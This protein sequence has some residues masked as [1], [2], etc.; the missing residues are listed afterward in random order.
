MKNTH[1]TITDVAREAGVSKSTVSK[2]LNHWP[3]ISAETTDR[4]NDVIARLGYIPNQRAVNFARGMSHS[5]VYIASAHRNTTYSNIFTFDIMCGASHELAH[6]GYSIALVDIE[7]TLKSGS[8]VADIFRAHS[9]DGFLIHASALS[10]DL[11]QNLRNIT[12]P[13]ITIG[14][15]DVDPSLNWI[16]TDNTLAGVCAAEHLLDCG[17]TNVLFV[18]P[19][20]E[21]LVSKQRLKGFQQYML[22][23]GHHVPRAHI[24]YTDGTRKGAYAAFKKYVE[25]YQVEDIEE[26][27]YL[28]DIDA[29]VCENNLIALSVMR[30]FN[31]KGIKTPDDL[32]FMTFDIHPYATIIDPL[33]TIVDVNAYDMGVAAADRILRCIDDPSTRVKEVTTLPVLLQGKT[34]ICSG[35][36]L[37]EFPELIP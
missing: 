29:V 15:P 21:E 16:D 19:Q 18:A 24:V 10:E 20:K 14:R 31:E 6:H 17:Y 8:T 2:V 27:G 36:D 30:V 33:P 4:V 26:K 22:D 32:G 28:P 25:E 13:H 1:I 37:G 3:S 23:H 5:I 34:T 35:N 7:E 9:A 12:L 11:V